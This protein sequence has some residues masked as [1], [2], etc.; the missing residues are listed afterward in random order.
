[1]LS[2]KIIFILKIIRTL[3]IH[4]VGKRAELLNI[5]AGGEHKLSPCSE[6]LKLA[7]EVLLFNRTWR[8][9][10]EMPAERRSTAAPTATTATRISYLEPRT[11]KMDNSNCV[12]NRAARKDSPRN[13]HHYVIFTILTAVSMNMSSGSLRLQVWQTSSDVSE[14]LAAFNISAMTATVCTSETPAHFYQTTRRSDT[15]NS[16]LETPLNLS[17][18]SK[19]CQETLFYCVFSHTLRGGGGCNLITLYK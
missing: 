19:C 16:R 7:T 4:S 15:E 12:T 5:K 8:T 11:G 14:V 17:R 3:Q 18:L 9:A 6:G 10:A 13:S 1:M 2:G